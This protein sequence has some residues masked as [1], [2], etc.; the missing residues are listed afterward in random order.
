MT[1]MTPTETHLFM[2]LPI[3]IL[4]VSSFSINPQVV[5]N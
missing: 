5:S 4:F 3:A 2:T 1:P